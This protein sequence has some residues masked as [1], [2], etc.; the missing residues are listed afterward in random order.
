M[1]D[2]T[3][4]NKKKRLIYKLVQKVHVQVGDNTPDCVT[5]GR[6]N[7]WLTWPGGMV[8][9]WFTDGPR[10]QSAPAPHSVGLC[11]L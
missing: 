5:K 4:N 11:G 2:E 9:G 3:K 10:Y 8:L 6:C 7:V 1:D